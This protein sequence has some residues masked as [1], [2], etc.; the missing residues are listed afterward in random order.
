MSGVLID[1]DII[2]NQGATGD[3]PAS[4]KVL[5][6]SERL[7]PHDHMDDLESL[8]YVLFYVCYGHDVDGR[9]LENPPEDL[10]LWTDP[11]S[12]PVKLG[13]YKKGFF[14]T[15]PIILHVTRFVG[16][17]RKVVKQ[18]MNNLR[19][20]FEERL[21]SIVVA[22][23]PDQSDESDTSNP[24]KTFQTYP[25]VNVPED[26]SRFLSLVSTAIEE[27]EVPV[28]LPPPSIPAA[29]QGSTSSKRCRPLE[30][31]SATPSAKRW[32]S[33]SSAAMH[34]V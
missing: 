15:Y 26:Y 8:F 30:E 21:D 1:F 3:F 19:F 4:V 10:K 34:M 17:E 22:L 2:A 24:P 14:L 32:E 28:L 7:G 23:A 27:L 20:F 31:D 13:Y 16:K 11:F 33:E 9:L 6:R 29:S 18:L 25:D 5:L 12:R